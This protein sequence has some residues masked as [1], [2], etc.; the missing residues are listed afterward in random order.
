MVVKR[1]SG[2]SRPPGTKRS[3]GGSPSARAAESGDAGTRPT[4]SR[5]ADRP[6]VG[7]GKSSGS[8]GGK[9]SASRTSAGSGNSSG[10]AEA[11]RGSSKRTKGRAL[12]GRLERGAAARSATSIMAEEQT[13]AAA[14]LMAEEQTTAAAALMAAPVAGVTGVT[15]AAMS[16]V[17]AAKLRAAS[18][19]GALQIKDALRGLEEVEEVL[20]AADAE[21]EAL[22]AQ[23]AAGVAFVEALGE[24]LGERPLSVQAARR[25][26]LAAAAAT[27]WE[28]V[29]GPLLSGQQV[30]ELMGGVSRQ[31][32]EQL[33]GSGRL[34][35]LEERSG[36]RRYPAWQFGEDSRPLATLVAAHQR[37]VTDG[38]MSPWS[39]ASWC[40]H[41]HDQLGGLSPL[42][43]AL[44]GRDP[45][46]LALVAGRDAAR[47]VV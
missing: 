22:S 36:Q 25:A 18:M 27:V 13:T 33:A 17:T 26:A 43:W 29:V 7:S 28:D 37:L 10:S 34:I 9:R 23:E 46:Y 19:R 14:A 42:D 20:R 47:N 40:V 5:S 11:T 44:A 32:L 4:G 16:A 8:A 45:D 3:S 6:S 15:G 2:E 31:R 38:E 21:A 35:V 12:S 1:S 30:R 39:A 24:V 41:E